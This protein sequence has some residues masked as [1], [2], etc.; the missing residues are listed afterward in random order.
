MIRRLTAALLALALLAGAGFACAQ[1]MPEVADAALRSVR[2]RAVGDLMVHQKQLDIAL[3]SGGG[4]NFH[5]QYALIADSLSNADYTMAN[6]E[7]TIGQYKGQAYSGFPRFNAPESLLQA[8]SDAGVDFLTL[9]N[10]HILDRYFEGLVQTV[11]FVEAYGF[12]HAGANRTREEAD[13]PRVFEVHGI[14]IGVLSYTAHAN[15]MERFCDPEAKEYGINYLYDA[16]Y[17]ADVRALEDAGAEIV[18]CLPH[19]GTEYLR[20]PD[21]IVRETAREMIAAGVDV[22]LGSHPHMVQPIEFVTV[23]TDAGARR[24]LVAW[25]LGNFISN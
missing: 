22:I 16:D 7:T 5:P 14:M 15:D 2:I 24:A 20:K 9:A 21:A 13:A 12:D 18:I 4:Y 17:A 11:D 1:E 25:S 23:E 8:I 6:L 10:N 19:W 3:E